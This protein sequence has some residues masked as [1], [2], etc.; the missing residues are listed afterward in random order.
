M[1][2]HFGID[3]ELSNVV[4]AYE[5][6]DVIVF[7]SIFAAE[8]YL[9]PIDVRN[10][11]YILYN[12]NARRLIPNVE[13]DSGSIERVVITFDENEPLHTS[14]LREILT[15]LLTFAGEKVEILEQMSLEHLVLE[16][17]KFRSQ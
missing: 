12:G 2:D 7:G 3:S 17:L 4:I 10:E 5:H 9:E 16:S 11:E 15:G 13:V 1:T 8:R 14:E 6:G